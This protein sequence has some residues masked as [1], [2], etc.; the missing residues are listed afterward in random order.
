M[1]LVG[2]SGEEHAVHADPIRR[3]DKPR[4]ERVAT[5]PMLECVLVVPELELEL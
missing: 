2:R 3:G 5:G 1:W 4:R